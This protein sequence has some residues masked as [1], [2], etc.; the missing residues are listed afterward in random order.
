MRDV[1]VIF[2][3]F[4]GQNCLSHLSGGKTVSAGV[5]VGIVP[6]NS[7]TSLPLRRRQLSALKHRVIDSAERRLL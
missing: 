1:N 4:W 6:V 2:L 5:V 7:V 3:F